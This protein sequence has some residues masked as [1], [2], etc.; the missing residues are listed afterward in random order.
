[1]SKCQVVIGSKQNNKSQ[2]GAAIII[3]TLVKK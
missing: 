2:L 1:M 3:N